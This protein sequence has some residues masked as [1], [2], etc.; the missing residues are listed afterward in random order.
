MKH[1]N[2]HMKK[3]RYFAQTNGK[4]GTAIIEMEIRYNYLFLQVLA[5]LLEPVNKFTVTTKYLFLLYMYQ[6]KLPVIY[7]TCNYNLCSPAVTLNW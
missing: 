1:V 3:V 5:W 2:T 6:I 4:P 7:V